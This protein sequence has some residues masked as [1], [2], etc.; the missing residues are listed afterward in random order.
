MRIPFNGCETNVQVLII[1]L[2]NALCVGFTHL[3]LPLN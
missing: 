1:S 3:N 2:C